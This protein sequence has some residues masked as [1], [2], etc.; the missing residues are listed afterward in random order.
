MAEKKSPTKSAYASAGVD[1]DAGNKAVQ[2]MKQY[3]KTT[4]NENCITDLG[5]FGGMF[6]FQDKILVASADGVG[7]K[8]KLAFQ[9]GKHDTIGQDLVNHCVNDILVMGAEPLFFLDY[10]ATGKLV[11]EVAAEVVKGLSIACKNN[12]CVLL[13]G[14]TAEMPSMY[15]PNEYDLAGFIVG[16]VD[17]KDVIDIKTI[18]PGDVVLGL[19]STGLQTNGYSLALKVFPPSKNTGK[20]ND[21]LMIPHGSFLNPIKA[22]R[23][24]VTIKGMAHITG[25]GFYENIPRAL[26]EGV[27]VCITKGTWHMPSIFNM[28]QERGKIDE[29]EMYRVFNMGIGLVVVVDKKDAEKALASLKESNQRAWQI[30][31][32][33]KGERKVVL[34]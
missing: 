10:F 13:G 24:V 9:T 8:I 30:G 33:V 25:G 23:K 3:V 27:N 18:K 17:R 19:A 4:K 20:L 21:V 14:E 22:L 6:K 32:V 28:I 11:P 34:K 2:L 15:Q 26:P 12:G 31:E 7:T 16:A 1:I 5:T 29:H